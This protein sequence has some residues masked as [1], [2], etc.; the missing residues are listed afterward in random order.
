MVRRVN[1]CFNK[2]KSVCAGVFDKMKARK[3]GFTLIELVVV[4]AIIAILAAM[5]LPALSAAKVRAQSVQC[6][7]NYKQLGL[8]WFMYTGDNNDKLVTNSDKHNSGNSVNWICAFGVVLDWTGNQNNTNTLFIND[9]KYALMADYI[10]QSLPIFICPADKFLGPAQSGFRSAGWTSRMRSCAM[11]GAMGDGTKYFAGGANGM[12]A[13]YNATKMSA[14]HTPGPSDCWV[15]MDE[16]PDSD[17]DATMYVDPTAGGT[18]GN[19]GIGTGNMSE[20]PGSMHA[21]SS[22]MVFADGHSEIHQWKNSQTIAPVKYITYWQDVAV[23]A[24]QDWVWWAQH[25]PQN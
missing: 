9:S 19:M 11:D 12:Q 18:P 3:T 17:D 13:Y 25:T 4:I 15:I 7:S 20:M 22:G 21:N 5:L 23:T 2:V 1:Y 24:D 10:A 14:L 8:A 16:H 6:M